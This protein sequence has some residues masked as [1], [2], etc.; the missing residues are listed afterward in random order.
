MIQDTLGRTADEQVLETAAG[1]S[2]HHDEVRPNVHGKC[3]QQLLRRALV[4]VH[5]E[6]FDRMLL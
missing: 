4:D 6:C 2:A 5:L 1:H 3:G